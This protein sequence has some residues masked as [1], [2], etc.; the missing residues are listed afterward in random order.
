M[1]LPLRPI[2]EGEMSEWFKEHA[3]KVCI[4]QKCIRGSNPRLSALPAEAP[5]PPGR[6]RRRVTKPTCH[7]VFGEKGR[8]TND[9]ARPKWTKQSRSS[10]KPKYYPNHQTKYRALLQL[11]NAEIWQ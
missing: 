9:S 8:L 5:R 10:N 1:E 11:P 2:Q 4:R 6:W 3:W 7:F